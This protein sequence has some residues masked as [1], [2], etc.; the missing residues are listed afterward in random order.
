MEMS[1]GECI[2]REVSVGEVSGRRS[3]RRG[4][5]LREIV[6]VGSVHEEVSDGEL[7]VYQ[8]ISETFSE[9]LL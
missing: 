8:F 7:S 1:Q 9:E 4:T 6:S 2:V 3:I 5:V